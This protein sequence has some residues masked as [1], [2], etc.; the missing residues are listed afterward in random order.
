MGKKHEYDSD[1]SV[2][3]W[4]IVQKLI[5][6]VI[7][8]CHYWKVYDDVDQKSDA[9]GKRTPETDEQKE[10]NFEAYGFDEKN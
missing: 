3:W 2:E 10:T 1:S 6:H 4:D 9:R 8:E 5:Y 7:F